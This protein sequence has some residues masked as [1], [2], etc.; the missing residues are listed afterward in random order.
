MD[1]IKKLLG[2]LRIGTSNDDKKTIGKRIF[3]LGVVGTIITLVLGLFAIYSLT[4][5]N[6]YSE[7]LEQAHHPEW[8]LSTQLKENVAEIGFTHL[9][10]QIKYDNGLYDYMMKY[11]GKIDSVINE[12]DDLAQRQDLPNLSNRISTLKSAAN[13]YKEA[14]VAFHETTEQAIAD[15]KRTKSSFQKAYQNWQEAINTLEGEKTIVAAKLLSEFTN[16]RKM[17]WSAVNSDNIEELKNVI[18]RLAET[19]QSL[20]NINEAP[21]LSNAAQN[22]LGSV[23]TSVKNNIAATKSYIASR[24]ELVKRGKDAFD[25]NQGIYWEAVD[26]NK[27]ARENANEQGNI[28]NTSVSNFIWILG[29][30]VALAVLGTLALSSWTS[31]STTAALK[32]IIDRLRGGAEQV[33]SSSHQLSSASQDL[34][35][36]SNQQ[37]ASLQETTSS[38]EEMAAQINQTDENSTEAEQAMQHA[39]PLVAQGVEAMDRMSG[40]MEEIKESALETSKIIKTIDDIAFQTNLLALNA[41]VEAA[42]AGEAGKGFAVVAEEVRN[43]AQRSAEAAKDTAQLIQQSQECTERGTE[44]A[45][46]VSENLAKIKD[47][48]GNVSILVEE[49]SAASKEQAVGIQQMNSTMAE[50]DGVVQKNASASEESASSAEEL[51]SQ[52]NELN[53]IVNELKQLAGGDTQQS[54]NDYSSSKQAKNRYLDQH[55]PK[56]FTNGHN[57]NDHSNQSSPNNDRSLGNELIPFDNDEDFSSF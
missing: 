12:S 5:I 22:S 30:G 34:A 54:D 51:S 40:A 25:G 45:D 53:D 57:N 15:R 23:I 37:A 42:R 55:S 33:K 26:M 29:I 8:R 24:E 9:R 35:E 14:I 7:K 28:T 41:A 20:E 4:T 38:L 17:F 18:P 21:S 52:A 2:D 19:H 48:A 44:M 43:L 56:E 46:E 11:F 32:N 47:S 39:Q 31:R 36:S 3:F 13:T 27:I 50:M 16:N 10:Y 6:G 1:F 49:I